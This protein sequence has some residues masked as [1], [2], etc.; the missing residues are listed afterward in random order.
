MLPLPHTLAEGLRDALRRRDADIAR[1]TADAGRTLDAYDA[2]SE[3]TRRLAVAAGYPPDVDPAS[4]FSGEDVAAAVASRMAA[5]RSENAELVAQNDA[6]E[7]Q[8][9]KLLHS[10]RVHAEQRGDAGLKYYGL[11]G[12]QLALVNEFAENLRAGAVELPLDDR[13]AELAKRLREV[14]A[15]LEEARGALY[16]ARG[17]AVAAAAASN[18]LAAGGT[19]STTGG[20]S[21]T[22]NSSQR[23]DE[24]A[25]AVSGADGTGAVAARA[26]AAAGLDTLRTLLRQVVSENWAL[27]REVRESTASAAHAASLAMAA[28][29]PGGSSWDPVRSALLL[30]PSS[31]AELGAV[32][33][34]LREA[35]EADVPLPEEPPSRESADGRRGNRDAEARTLTVAAL[36]PPPARVRTVLARLMNANEE[37]AVMARREARAAAAARAEAAAARHAETEE[38]A[39]RSVGDAAAAAAPAAPQAAPP[40][41]SQAQTALAAWAAQLLLRGATS[42]AARALAQQL[43]A[44]QGVASGA[45]A[46]LD[47]ATPVQLRAALRAAHAAIAT[48]I[49]E[50]AEREAAAAALE[51][52]AREARDSTTALAARHADTCR[53]AASAAEAAEAAVTAARRAAADADARAD[54]QSAR[55]AR[56]EAGLQALEALQR[57][58]GDDGKLRR[59]DGDGSGDSIVSVAALTRQLALLE[60]AHPILSRKYEL[61]RSELAA[62]RAAQRNAEAALLECD[63]HARTR[64]A[65]LEGA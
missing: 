24:A 16:A 40:L 37:L 20:P 12:Q 54:A 6:L 53:A 36:S 9:S 60:V 50:L 42:P 31:D 45:A 61:L 65:Y 33:A 64:I 13:S 23:P 38:R 35:E 39:S 29:A 43:P 49:E 4:I 22:W 27:R 59:L 57:P 34:A 19:G 11:T 55:A 47:T 5:L 10:L 2:L 62:A 56:L 21:G 41:S 8:R 1:L 32:A 51:A 30:T 58:E 3:V 14:S 26:A 18:A 63:A 15:E 46:T 17:A 25:A 7:A 28:A 52:A 44:L 48:A